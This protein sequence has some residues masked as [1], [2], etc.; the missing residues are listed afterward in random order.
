MGERSGGVS[1]PYRKVRNRQDG[2]SYSDYQFQILIGR[3]VTE[4]QTPDGGVVKVSN[5]Y[6][7]VRN[8]QLSAP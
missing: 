1:N 8:S 2:K 4:T 7:K 6:R 5:P 3:F